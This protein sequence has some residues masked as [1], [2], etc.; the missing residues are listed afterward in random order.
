M[1]APLLKIEHHGRDLFRLDYPTVALV[2]DF[3][4]LAEH[5]TEIAPTEKYRSGSVPAPE[6]IFFSMVR[7][8][9]MND[10]LLAGS[11]HR[12]LDRNQAV[13]TTVPR[14]QIATL[15]VLESSANALS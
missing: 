8:K 5:A 4:V 11:T 3:P 14:A 1:A 15:Q 9:T 7:S 10:R 12:S 2:A 6:H 13:N